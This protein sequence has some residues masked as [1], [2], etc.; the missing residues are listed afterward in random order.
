MRYQIFGA[1]DGT[2]GGAFRGVSQTVAFA[3]AGFPPKSAL[4]F[5]EVIRS[6]GR[7]F[8]TGPLGIGQPQPPGAVVGIIEAWPAQHGAHYITAQLGRGVG[9]EPLAP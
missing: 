1:A 5:V 7:N 9:A 8:Q 6:D 3:L 4:T 2:S